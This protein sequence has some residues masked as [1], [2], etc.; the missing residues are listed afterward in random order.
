VNGYAAGMPQR[1][2]LVVAF[3]V[4]ASCAPPGGAASVSVLVD[5]EAGGTVALDDGTRLQIPPGALGE[6]TTITMARPDPAVL[7][8]AHVA[9]VELTPSGLELSAPA[10]LTLPFSPARATDDVDL[11]LEVM[12]EANPLD[13]A[14]DE[15]QPFVAVPDAAR[16]GDAFTAP[17]THFSWYS[18]FGHRR[19][20]M[21]LELPGRTLQNGDILYALIDA[22]GYRN[23]TDRPMHVGMF[24]ENE[25]DDGVIESTL[26]DPGCTPNYLEGVERHSYDGDPG[27][28]RLCGA[29]VF[30]GARRPKGEL[31][32]AM[33]SA[34]VAA[35]A[36][37]LDKP[38]GIIALNNSERVGIIAGGISCVELTEDSWEEAGVNI[39]LTP[40]A[41][42]W[43]Q[44]QFENT[45]PVDSITVQIE[46]G[47]LVVPV[48][49]AVHRQNQ[50]D[51][52]RY[53]TGFMPNGV[54]MELTITADPNVFEDGRAT[55]VEPSS[56]PQALKDLV[57]VPGQDDADRTVTFTFRL[58]VPSTGAETEQ[59]LAVK[60]QG[61][62]VCVLDPPPEVYVLGT[63]AGTTSSGSF[64]L[65][66]KV[67]FSEQEV[68]GPSFYLTTQ[69][70]SS[71]TCVS[72]FDRNGNLGMQL[73][74]IPL[75]QP[76]VD[77]TV[78][79]TVD[80]GT[81]AGARNTDITCAPDP[82]ASGAYHFYNGESVSGTVTYRMSTSC[83]APTL[84]FDLTGSETEPD[85]STL[86]ETTS[87]CAFT[88]TFTPD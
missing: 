85:Q 88:A 37:R 7:Q 41:L 84:T 70:C 30:V 63:L 21:G 46:D 54:P 78:V 74:N 24:V 4:A 81:I 31:T 25:R 61:G 82:D 38:Y 3:F 57:F 2:P 34:A 43:P 9:A 32:A 45:V 27:F 11:V 44:D 36:S 29:H 18:I 69:D 86:E 14:G 51:E 42:L 56:S 17:I 65:P 48:V 79:H 28:R 80:G 12:S 16:V 52:G 1:A 5:A 39:S 53:D 72:T 22:V 49:G 83:D 58:R 35:A 59:K 77:K 33:R 75:P 68:F 20:Y 55:I 47:A 19:L 64:S 10:T 6:D 50:G 62:A 8:G 26:P 76:G 23:A 15:I 13:R 67:A 60:V 73:T 66:A 40:D 71:G 87:T